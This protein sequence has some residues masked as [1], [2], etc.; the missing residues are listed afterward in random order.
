MF[1][2]LIDSANP[3]NSSEP[4]ES[5]AARVAMSS[6]RVRSGIGRALIIAGVF[7]CSLERAAKSNVMEFRIPHR[8]AVFLLY[9]LPCSKFPFRV[10]TKAHS[11][12]VKNLRGG[13]M[14]AMID[15]MLVE[16]DM[17]RNASLNE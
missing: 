7:I 4:T 11:E 15:R 14:D 6:W 17:L 3:S 8:Y 2:T 9:S 10:N 5:F 13:I 1:S 16:L 12:C